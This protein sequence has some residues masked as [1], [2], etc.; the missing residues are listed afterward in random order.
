[1]ALGGS[2]RGR[3]TW[4]RR[5][6]RVSR[7]PDTPRRGLVPALCSPSNPAMP[8][9]PPLQPGVE[10]PRLAPGPR[11]SRQARDQRTRGNGRGHSIGRQ[12]ARR[13][14][15]RPIRRRGMGGAKAETARAA[16]TTT[17]RQGA[18]EGCAAGRGGA[19]AAS[20][21]PPGRERLGVH[22]PG[23]AWSPLRADLVGALAPQAPPLVFFFFV[24]FGLF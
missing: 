17:R 7:N 15:E 22:I 19:R 3:G 4:E 16:G 24:S 6:A 12:K 9:L 13:L 1:M 21:R 8:Y 18:A 10:R 14:L 23:R 11:K 2:G 5:G 20:R